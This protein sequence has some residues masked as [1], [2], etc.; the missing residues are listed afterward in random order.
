MPFFLLSTRLLNHLHF[1]LHFA[2]FY[3]AANSTAMIKK[4]N[5]SVIFFDKFGFLYKCNLLFN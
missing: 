1:K 4:P 2:L 5:L 3:Y